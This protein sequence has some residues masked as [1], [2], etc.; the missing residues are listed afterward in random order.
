M[1]RGLTGLYTPFTSYEQI[2]LPQ[3]PD[4]SAPGAARLLSVAIP[5]IDIRSLQYGVA[6]GAC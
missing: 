3:A 1:R 5:G 4:Q 2:S 6:R